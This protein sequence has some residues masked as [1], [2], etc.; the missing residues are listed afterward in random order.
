L[1]ATPLQSKSPVRC[2]KILHMI[3]KFCLRRD[4]C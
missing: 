2:R 3:D 4:G 1:H